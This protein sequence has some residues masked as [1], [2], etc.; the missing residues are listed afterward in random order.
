[1]EPT[2]LE[3]VYGPRQVENIR[4]ITELTGDPV[5]AWEV[6]G[7]LSSPNEVEVIFGS[8]GMPLMT[9]DILDAAP[10]LRAV[11]YGA[12]TVKSFAT[13][14]LFERGIVLTNA[15][16]P[17]AIPVA[18][19]CLATILF[20]LKLGWRHC[21][22]INRE[23]AWSRDPNDIAGAYEA[24][25]GLISLG[26]IGWKTPELLEPF[27]LRK[28][29]YSTS[30]TAERAMELGVE[31]ATLDEIFQQSDVI[32]LHTPALPSTYHMIKPRHLRMMRPNATFINTARGSVVDQKGLIE[33]MK[34]RPDLSA[35]L[36]VTDPEPPQAGDE[37]T[38]VDNIFLTPHIAGSLGNECRRLGQTAI[39]ECERYLMGEPLLYPVC[40]E[41]LAAMA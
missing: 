1:M 23:H 22:R 20:S 32:S 21:R 16:V 28:L 40:E 18:E 25:V 19:Y 29:V 27:N 3:K 9:R 24:T 11:F 15:S 17:N 37:I 2:R 13:P 33:V 8:W 12:G 14:E 38:M 34:E 31:R 26:A 41:D 36:D 5:T 7:D 10:N 30:L 39:D 35:I 4:R 6:L